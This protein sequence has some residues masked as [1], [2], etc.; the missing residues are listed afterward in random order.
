MSVNKRK[1]FSKLFKEFLLG[2]NLRFQ[3]TFQAQKS[4][5]TWR[6]AV[7]IRTVLFFFF[8]ALNSGINFR[9]LLD[10]CSR[11]PFLIYNSI[12]KLKIMMM[13]HEIYYYWYVYYSGLLVCAQSLNVYFISFHFIYFKT[14]FFFFLCSQDWPSH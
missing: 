14:N 7:M 6:I 5:V 4:N 8:R 1:Q 9:F 11:E 12:C 3:I 10:P 13:M 2:V